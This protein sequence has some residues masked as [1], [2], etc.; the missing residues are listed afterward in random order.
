MSVCY[1]PI[2]AYKDADGNI[3]FNNDKGRG[4]H[5]LKLPC[6]QCIGCRLNHAEGWAI[7]MIHEAQLHD[8][9]SFLTLTY[10]DENLPINGSLQY[11]DVTKFIK[12]LRKVLSLTPYKNKIKYFRVGEYGENFSRP[13]YHIILFGFNFSYQLKY[14]NKINEK[15]LL[16]TKPHN[17]YS[18]C[19]LNDLWTFGRCEIGDVNYNTCMYVA[20][21]ITKKVNG[22]Q[23]QAH[24]ERLN[25]FGEYIQLEQ[26]KSSMSRKNAIGKEWLQKY[27]TDVYP[28]DFCVH[29]GR[30]LK[31]P[32]YYDKYLE[33]NNPE[34]YEAVKL[35][36]ESSQI[37]RVNDSDALVT[38]YEVKILTAKANSHR[39]LEGSASTLESDDKILEYLKNQK[40]HLRAIA[41]KDLL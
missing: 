28:K 34:L 16:R 41:K 22:Q 8:E 15:K 6:S 24:Y 14:K 9:N 33:K 31:I 17:Y 13:H 20:K 29:E 21:Y 3:I 27:Y 11:E 40:N 38:S 36:R 2:R 4:I 32:K 19:L 37:S 35:E 18:S 23:K 1:A 10:S 25:E 30:K 12:K 7:R 26:E 5:E 39:S